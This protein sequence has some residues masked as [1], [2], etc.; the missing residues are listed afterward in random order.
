MPLSWM[1]IKMKFVFISFFVVLLSACTHYSISDAGLLKNSSAP[2][3]LK[4]EELKAFPL[5][6][7]ADMSCYSNRAGR[8]IVT[9][10][11]NEARLNKI[12]KL[13][14]E[15]GLSAVPV[16]DDESAPQI[17]VELESINGFVERVTGLF[18]ILTLGLSPL[19]HYD[20]YIV[21]FKDPNNLVKITKEV[22]ISSHSSWF[23]LLFTNPDGLQE[24]TIKYRAE[25]NLI[26]SVLDDANVGTNARD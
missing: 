1:N 18:N 7:D 3:S 11:S 25:N 8:S 16:V 4:P 20:D 23:S 24:G 9:K 6:I 21:T 15:R 10:C 17:S 22:R 14:E 12:V 5:A 19:Y 13:F 26:R 2:G